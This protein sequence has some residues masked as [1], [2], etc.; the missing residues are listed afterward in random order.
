M[1]NVY[2][3]WQGNDG[4]EYGSYAIYIQQ[5]NKQEVKILRNKSS[6]EQL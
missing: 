3:V 6:N 4:M 2:T 1:W 5:I